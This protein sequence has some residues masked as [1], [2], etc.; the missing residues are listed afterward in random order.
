LGE[1]KIFVEA[2]QKAVCGGLPRFFAVSA[3]Y[4]EEGKVKKRYHCAWQIQFCGESPRE[5]SFIVDVNDYDSASLGDYVTIDFATRFE[6]EYR[7]RF[8]EK[9]QIWT[10]ADLHR[11]I[12]RKARGRRIS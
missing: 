5:W 4:V 7:R 10:D 2:L 6:F 1:P 12:Y 3:V 11:L 8:E 9:Y